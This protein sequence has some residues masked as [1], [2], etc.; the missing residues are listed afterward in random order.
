MKKLLPLILCYL[1]DFH[2]WTT[3]FIERGEKVQEGITMHSTSEEIM[4][5]FKKDTIMYCKHCEKVSRLSRF[6]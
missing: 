5:A 6:K 4:I 1:F 3:D 2:E